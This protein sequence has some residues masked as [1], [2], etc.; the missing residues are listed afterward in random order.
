MEAFKA[1][2]IEYLLKP[3]SY[4]RFKTAVKRELGCSLSEETKILYSKLIRRKIPHKPVE[5]TGAIRKEISGLLI[6]GP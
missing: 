5:R 4:E 3:F 2:G 1:N 6:S